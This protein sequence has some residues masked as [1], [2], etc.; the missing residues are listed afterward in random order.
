MEYKTR[1]KITKGVGGLYSIELADAE[2]HKKIYGD[3]P[4]P[5]GGARVVCH[6]KGSFRHENIKPYVGD[7]VEVTYS[8]MSF[9]TDGDTVTPDANGAG[10]VISS[11]CDRRNSLIRPPIANVDYM[12]VTT[13]CASP[14]P[15]LETVDK[16]L[17]ILEF[18]GIEPIIVISKS[19]LRPKRAEEIGEIYRKAGFKAFVL[20][21]REGNGAAEIKKFIFDTLPSHT[22]AFCGASGVGKST[23]ISLIFPEL[24]LATGEISQKIER[25]KHTTRCTELFAIETD[26][27][28]GYIADTPGFSMLDFERFDFFSKDDLPNTFRE[29]NEYIGQCRYTKCSHTKEQGCAIVEAV[30]QGKIPKTR[31]DSFVSLFGILKNKKE[32]DK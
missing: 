10:V 25:G 24:Q 3:M 29:M 15:V 4:S 12:F 28:R 30:R 19:E 7:S 14:E 21:C 9:T 11:I 23:L 31:H 13:A 8:D 1:G 6:A 26:R 27:G 18:N 20:S 32:W 16:T 17:S 22:I 2:T 5:L